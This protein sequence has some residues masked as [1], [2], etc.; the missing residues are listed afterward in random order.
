ME[1]GRIVEDGNHHTLL[2]QDGYYARLH[3]HQLLSEAIKEAEREAQEAQ[4]TQTGAEAEASAP[5]AA[6]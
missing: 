2:A 5:V 1:K 4:K 3:R 6:D